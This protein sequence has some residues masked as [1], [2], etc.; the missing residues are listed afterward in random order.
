MRATLGTEQGE[1]I[2]ISS[3]RGV[4][5]HQVDLIINGSVHSFT[6]AEAFSVAYYLLAMAHER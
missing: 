4:G 2:L 6:R 5:E 1:D 3:T